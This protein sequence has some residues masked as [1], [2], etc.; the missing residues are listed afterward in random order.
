MNLKFNKFQAWIGWVR[1]L[2]RMYKSDISR[3][4]RETE[5][6]KFHSLFLWELGKMVKNIGYK[7]VLLTK[8]RFSNSKKPACGLEET[9]AVALSW[10]KVWSNNFTPSTR[11]GPRDS[12]FF[13]YPYIIAC[14][15]FSLSHFISQLIID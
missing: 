1:E 3:R 9:T 7:I 2:W 6:R 4:E 14:R 5:R 10:S 13:L 12:H 15:D 8:F 11:S